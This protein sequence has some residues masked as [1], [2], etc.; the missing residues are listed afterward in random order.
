MSIARKSGTAQRASGTTV[1]AAL[2]T[3]IWLALATHMRADEPAA[4][5]PPAATATP[6]P[7][8]PLSDGATAAAAPPIDFQSQIRPIFKQH[9]DGCHGAEK[10]SGG[11]RLDSVV[12]AKEKGDSGKPI[13]GGTLETN[14]LYA[15]VSSDDRTYRMPK[16]AK[17]LS[18][19][20][21]ARLKQWVQ[22]GTPWPDTTVVPTAGAPFYERW[23]LASEAFASLHEAEIQFVQPFVYGFLVVQVGLF[24]VGRMK[25]AYQQGTSRALDSRVCRACGRLRSSELMLVWL[26]SVAALAGLW[27]IGRDRHLTAQLT[28]SRMVV[29]QQTNH[30]AHTVFG[31]PPKPVRFDR[32]KQISGVY[33]RGNCER[34]EELFNGGNYLTS[35][36]RIALVDAKHN[37]VSLGSPWPEKGLF[38]RMEIER[39]PGTTDALFS[40]ELMDNVFLSEQFFEPGTNTTPEQPLVKLET[41]EVGQRWVAYAPVNAP[42]TKQMS[43]GLIYIYTGSSSD[44]AVRGEP[45]Y[46]IRYDLSFAGG[47]L[48]GESDLWMNSFG[49]GAFEVPSVDKKLPYREWFDDQPLPTIV[50]TNTTDPKLLGIDERVEQGLISAPTAPPAKGD[51]APP[52][53][54][55]PASPPE[56]ANP[57]DATKATA[58]PSSDE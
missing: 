14:E 48:N 44:K 23:L 40:K 26:L 53:S 8:S 43:Q 55:V 7:G 22:E 9:C 24:V 38:V 21:L 13:V 51:A 16:N 29:Q 58:K 30:W 36:F 39:A 57:P 19:D 34:N 2:L 31:Y 12:F 56:A 18:A 35:T 32:P 27:M 15:R 45:H 37:E 6:S 52:E 3:L 33:Y 50:G 47:M 10:R 25:R 17:P 49:N 4:D 42:D 41:L 54:P 5:A 46:A 11:L 1:L 28:K 20:E